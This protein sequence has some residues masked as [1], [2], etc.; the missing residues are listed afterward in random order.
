MGCLKTIVGSI[1]ISEILPS[2]DLVIINCNTNMLMPK[3]VSRIIVKKAGIKKLEE[4][5]NNK[6]ISSGDIKITPGFNIKEDIMLLRFPNE[7][8]KKEY[9]K[10]INSM[11]DL[12]SIN[13]YKNVLIPNLYFNDYIKGISKD[14]HK[15][16]DKFLIN[17]NINI[18]IIF[19]NKKDYNIF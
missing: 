4:Y 14:I 11:L 10:I 13:E 7:N 3:S 8:N 9:L 12:I 19:N 17:K 18:D 16:I 2:Y 15:M 6:Y 1:S 5:I